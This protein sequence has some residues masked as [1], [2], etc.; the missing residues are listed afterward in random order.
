MATCRSQVEL[1]DEN[2]GQAG[3]GGEKGSYKY[4]LGKI[5]LYTSQVKHILWF[6]GLAGHFRRSCGAE[7]GG[8]GGQSVPA[9]GKYPHF[10][11]H[12]YLILLTLAR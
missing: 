11:A 2:G 8:F 3:S 4:K 7:L 6:S 10:G 12:K 1:G 9:S 5:K